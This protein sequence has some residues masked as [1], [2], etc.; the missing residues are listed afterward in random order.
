MGK[1][2]MEIMEKRK[3]VRTYERTPIREEAYA[4]VMEYLA[5]EG[6]LRGPLG[7]TAAVE[8]I[9]AK[10]GTAE[11]AGVK[12]GAYGIIKNPQAYLVGVVQN[13]KQALLEFGYIFHKLIL[14]ATGLGLGTCWMGGTFN[15]K[16]FSREIELAPGEIIPCITP[17]GYA[18]EKQRLVDSTMRYIA[19][20]DQRKPW[21]E[22]F[23]HA[24]FGRVLTREAA[25]ELA[26]PLEMV[27]QGPSASNKQPWRVVL[28]EDRKQAH[29]YLQPTPN[30]SGNKLGF[31]MQRIDIGIAACSFGLACRE[32]DFSG[33]WTQ[34]D[35]MLNVPGPHTEY[36]L[37]YTLS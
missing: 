31:E 26:A 9:A 13:G 35:P 17:L 1:T 21:E 18:S 25:G 4:S 15:R 12:L 10:G 16:S 30:Y 24:E 28:S 11:A 7:G 19:K 5:Q 36:M 20:A 3:S 22:L 2:L 8:W 27:R 37:S 33:G 6:N 34:Q 14:H 32:L 23:H 29:F